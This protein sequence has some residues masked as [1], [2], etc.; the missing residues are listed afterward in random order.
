MARVPRDLAGTLEL[1]LW[2]RRFN[3]LAGFDLGFLQFCELFSSQA[4]AWYV[5][6]RVSSLVGV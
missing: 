5:G 1:L 4:L 2:L 3:R 6:F